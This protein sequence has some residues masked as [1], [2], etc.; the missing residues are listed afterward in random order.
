MIAKLRPMVEEQHLLVGMKDDE[1][2]KETLEKQNK[3]MA[4]EE[5]F[6]SLDE[7]S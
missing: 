7:S 2:L 1:T 5:V 4:V 6:M 3:K